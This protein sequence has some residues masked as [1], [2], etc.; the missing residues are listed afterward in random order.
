MRLKGNANIWCI[1]ARV[2][3]VFKVFSKNHTNAVEIKIE[4]SCKTRFSKTIY[5]SNHKGV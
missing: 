5:T 3:S 4:S 2:L 1:N